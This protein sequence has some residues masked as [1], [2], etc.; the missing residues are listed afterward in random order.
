M[1]NLVLFCKTY[2]GDAARVEILKKSVDRFNAD[3]LPFY[4]ICPQ[5]DMDFLKKRLCHGH[6]TYE[7]CFVSDEDVLSAA[8]LYPQKQGWKEQQVLKLAFYKLGLCKHW[9]IFDSDCYFIS[10]FYFSDFMFDENTP[11]FYMSESLTQEPCFDFVRQ[12][13]GRK[14]KTYSFIYNSQVFSAAVLQDMEAN[15]LLKRQLTFQDLI[16][17]HGYEFQWY[18]EWFLKCAI[19]PLYWTSGRVKVYWNEQLYADDRQKGVRVADLAASGYRAVL[20]NNGW[21][22]DVVYRDP[23]LGRWFRA[24][25]ASSALLNARTPGGGVALAR[26]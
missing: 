16:A 14:G 10:T 25:R 1:H 3:R 12:Y 23:Q 2:Q 20:L 22:K 13:L 19:F 9:A 24:L 5:A 8:G 7:L 4:I 6:E 18:G 15:L 11:Y 17:L 26:T 21:V